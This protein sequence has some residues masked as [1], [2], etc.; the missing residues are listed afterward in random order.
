V[1]PDVEEIERRDRRSL[2]QRRDVVAVAPS[3][4]MKLIEPVAVDLVVPA[5][6]GTEWGVAA[7]ASD[8][9]PFTGDGVVVCELDTGIDAAHP[10]FAGVAV[11]QNDFTGTGNG[12][13]HGHGTRLRARSSGAPSKA[14]ASASRRA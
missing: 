12:D 6:A 1:A 14:G 3:M 4:P 10:A 5:A 13:L 9:S 7:V 11:E 2:L 8:T